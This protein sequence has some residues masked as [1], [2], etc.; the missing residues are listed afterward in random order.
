MR[1]F[2]L[3]CRGAVVRLRQALE[4]ELTHTAYAAW[5]AHLLPSK[6]AADVL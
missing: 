2:S 4:P 6:A 5:A 3:D 1:S